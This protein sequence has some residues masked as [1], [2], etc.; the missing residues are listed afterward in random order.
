MELYGFGEII[1]QEQLEVM[2]DQIQQLPQS[3]HLQEETI[4]NNV[5]LMVEHVQQSKPM[6]PYGF[7]VIILMDD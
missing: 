1:I 3:P 5:L 2:V 6:E 4:G 7:G